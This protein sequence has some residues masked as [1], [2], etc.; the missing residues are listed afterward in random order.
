MIVQHEKY[1]ANSVIYLIPIPNENYIPLA[2]LLSW[3]H[4]FKF[5]RDFDKYAKVSFFETYSY[6]ELN[7]L[8]E[9][10]L[11]ND[12]K[13]QTDQQ[14]YLN[15]GIST[16]TYSSTASIDNIIKRNRIISVLR[17]Q[18]SQNKYISGW[19]LFGVPLPLNQIDCV[20]C[21]T[22]HKDKVLGVIN[23]ILEN[24]EIDNSLL[25]IW[26]NSNLRLRG[27]DYF[28]SIKAKV[29]SYIKGLE[30]QG[31]KSVG[32]SQIPFFKII[33]LPK[34]KDLNEKKEYIRSIY[35]KMITL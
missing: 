2:Q 20:F 7:Y 4:C 6:N 9:I 15:F 24:K 13:I 16:I 31:I 34:F 32:M 28:K 17:Q 26:Y 30:N 1:N 18:R 14:K 22:V 8:N 25:E 29:N 27:S 3:M 10:D 33:I 21:V 11:L 12:F 23:C 19:G 5:R 35:K